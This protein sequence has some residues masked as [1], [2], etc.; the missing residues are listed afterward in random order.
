MMG[1]VFEFVWTLL[2]PMIHV[3]AF[4]TAVT[5]VLLTA[6]F[7][8]V[9]PKRRHIIHSEGNELPNED[10]QPGSGH[11]ELV[12]PRE[13]AA[14]TQHLHASHQMTSR[15]SACTCEERLPSRMCLGKKLSATPWWIQKDQLDGAYRTLRSGSR[16]CMKGVQ[17]HIHRT[18][19]ES[20]L[21]DL[22]CRGRQGSE[23]GCRS[24]E[25]DVQ[26]AHSPEEPHWRRCS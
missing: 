9:R 20:G 8:A 6:I 18:N 13:R 15:I 10:N 25:G 11:A 4:L 17:W 21:N 16:Q 5:V 24:A 22:G 23:G 14:G 3:A 12:T 26:V 2:A 7:D 1:A 19:L